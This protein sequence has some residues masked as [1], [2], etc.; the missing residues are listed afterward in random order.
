[1]LLQCLLEKYYLSKICILKSKE[2]IYS[3]GNTKYKEVERYSC[4]CNIISTTWFVLLYVTRIDAQHWYTRYGYTKMLEG[5]KVEK[6][7]MKLIDSQKFVINHP[8]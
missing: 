8:Q 7:N 1:M 2:C 6:I 4:E 5:S 3:Q